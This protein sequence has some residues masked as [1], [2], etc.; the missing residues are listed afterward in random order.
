MASHAL[1]IANSLAAEGASGTSTLNPATATFPPFNNILKD[2]EDN[3]ALKNSMG[4][5]VV[6][7]FKG[8]ETEKRGVTP[9]LPIA[10]PA[11]GVAGSD[12]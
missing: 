5:T 3:E 9:L 4:S 11:T 10:V 1:S 2:V 12:E 7:K 8:D 6:A